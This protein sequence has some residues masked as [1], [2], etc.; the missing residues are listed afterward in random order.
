M[1]TKI[2][3]ASEEAIQEAAQLLREGQLVG[4]PTETVYGLGAN[5]FDEAAVRSIF[6]AK[7]RP[8]DNPLIVHVS[9]PEEAEPLCEV[10]ETARTL[11]KAF[12]PGPL[13]MLMKRKSCISDV[14]T[15]GLPSVAIRIPSH[16][17]A[18]RLLEVC[19][20]PVAAPSANTSGKPSPTTAQHVVDDLHGK[21][22]L[23]LDGGECQ[24]GLESTVID[25][26]APIPTVLR[27]GGVTTEML[28]TVL[29]EVKVADSVL[30]PLRE[31]EKALSPGMRYRHY[32]PSGKLTMVKGTP[33]HV[34][35][36]IRRHAE[37]TL[38]N[39][40]AVRIFAFE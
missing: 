10:T 16:P 15:A 22:P 30:R 36:C 21:L 6:A 17:V 40:Q 13:T 34:E 27:P 33:E 38:Q 5:A 23:I 39:V 37:E 31:G 12:C 4:I 19:G 7:G 29:K 14:V 24:V 3:P 25:L 28:L 18:H 32:A 26:T 11:M 20:V 1:E 8:A 9:R 35:R 2:L